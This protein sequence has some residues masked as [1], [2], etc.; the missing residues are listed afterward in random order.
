MT[1][2]AFLAL[3]AA[4]TLLMAPSLVLGS[5]VTHS[6]PQNLTW[7]TQFAEQFRAGVP[8]PRW[9][10]ESFDG[11]GGPAFYFYPPMP[12]WADALLSVVTFDALTVP[13]RLAVASALLLLASG[14]AMQAWL[15]Q[16]TANARAALWG[17]IAYMAAPYHLLDHYMRGAHAEFTAF[18]FLPLVLLAVR[19]PVL[20]AVC[21]GGL[22]MS[23]LPTALLLSAT[24]LPAWA[25][26]SLRNRREV[27]EL[28]MAAL[29]GA[30]LAGIYLLPALS[31]QGW[32]SAEQ[33][34]APF[35]RVERWFLVTPEQWPEPY[36]MQI[37]L[38]MAVAYAM[39]SVGIWAFFRTRREAIFWAA[40]STVC[41]FLL[42]GLVPWFWS[43]PQLAKVQFPWRLM[44]LVELAVIT[45]FCHARPPLHRGTV[46]LLAAAAAALAPGL[47]L[48]VGDT[49]E[50]VDYALARG[51]LAMR[52][53]KEYE[54]RGYPQD[55]ALGY[56]QLGLE[57]VAGVP[58]IACTPPPRLCRATAERFGAMRIEIDADGPTEVVLRRFFFLS[59]QLDPPLALAPT[60]RLRLVSF[61]APAGRHAWQLQQRVLTIERIGWTASGLSLLLLVLLRA[62]NRP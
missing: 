22:L 46:Y 31:L 49:L 41:L 53:V 38:S 36:I 35:Y 26:C 30:G 56:A 37:V 39:L 33:L 1:G 20:F 42:A 60:E 25:I 54:P 28:A 23:H 17:A 10:P 32:I 5:F 61:V 62:L 8:Y 43:L 15:V 11:L 7:A 18:V 21:Y 24:I 19:R 58:P 4:A 50:R 29:L 9:M 45:A 14:L 34:W 51:P 57:P 6:S 59:W 48:A 55:K 16:Q 44:G 27:L 40:T 12:F 3:L 13:Y 47:A 2:R 52:D